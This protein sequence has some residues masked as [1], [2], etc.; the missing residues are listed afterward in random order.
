MPD[1]LCCG[2]HEQVRSAGFI[3]DRDGVVRFAEE[4]PASQARDQ[5]GW[6]KALAAVA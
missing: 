3:I 6:R 1:F 5:D 2:D 4:L